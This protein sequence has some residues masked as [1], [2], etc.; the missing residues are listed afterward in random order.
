MENKKV[1]ELEPYTPDEEY[2]EYQNDMQS[3][4]QEDIEEASA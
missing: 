4:V 2:V 1:E 3:Q